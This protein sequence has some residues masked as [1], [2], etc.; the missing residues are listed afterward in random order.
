MLSAAWKEDRTYIE[1]KY[2]EM[3]TDPATGLSNE[4]I[5]AGLDRMFEENTA[6]SHARLKAMGFDYVLSNARLNICEHDWFVFIS[7]WNQKSMDRAF[8]SRWYGEV[9]EICA[10]LLSEMDA[11]HN[12]AKS[13]LLYLDYCHSVP[14]WDAVLQLGFPGLRARA[15]YYRR[16]HEGKEAEQDDFLYANSQKSDAKQKACCGLKPRQRD[17]FDAI[18]IEYDA[19]L[20]F[21]GRAAEYARAQENEKCDRIAECLEHLR[22]GA[23]GDTYECLQAIWLYFLLSEYVDCLQVRSFGN[24]DRVLYPYYK[25][26]IETGRYTVD[27][28]CEFFAAFL[29]QASAMNYYWGHPFYF[30]GTNMDGSS[31]VNELSYLIL[32]VYDELGIYDPKLQIKLDR[33]TPRA[34]V[35]KILEMIRGGHSSFNFVCEPA[36]ERTML[37]Y[38][39]TL[40]EARR[41]DIKGCYEY[42]VR[43]DA[44]DTASVHVNLPKAVELALHDG[45]DFFS[46]FQ[47]GP[48]TGAAESFETFENF[49]SAFLRQADEIYERGF[50]IINAFESHTAQVNPTPMFSA[51]IRTSLEQAYDA[52][53]GGTK[54]TSS[55]V[56]LCCPAT[57]ADSLAMIKKYVFDRG[58]LTL[59]ELRDILD[60]NW[61]GAELLRRKILND[62]DKWGNNRELPDAIFKD[63]TEHI[64]RENNSRRNARGGVYCTSLHNAKQFL[65]MGWKTAATPDGRFS[66]EECS[67]NASSV[68]GMNRDGATALIASI[69]KLDSRLFMGDFPVDIC[70]SPGTVA[71]RD[72]LDAMY[73]LL[74]TYL[75]NYGHAIHFN[76][77]SADTLRDAKAHPEKYKDLQVRVCGWNVLWNSLTEAE[78]DFYIRQAEAAQ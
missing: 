3:I 42:A 75:N 46:S 51:T 31:A 39:Y 47:S 2:R 9:R 53:S 45:Y 7:E 32:D 78:Q 59:A 68:Q 56:L 40:E 35:D 23:P 67:K 73:G 26:D 8:C 18:D 6:L 25:H 17:Y 50:A 16:V 12:D 20:R 38:G 65:E 61:E 10:P 41:A 24:L 33:N 15:A 64:A 36:I 54:H 49:Y 1:R 55:D 19:I 57:A 37:S 28:I 30:G 21:L 43:G 77:F 14:D 34:F 48:H 72:G 52:Y 60:R 71:G 4:E 29:M 74:M 62:R 69:G 13:H 11:K 66:G 70:L 5:R 22:D 63:L 58:E 27:Q 44:V 76:I